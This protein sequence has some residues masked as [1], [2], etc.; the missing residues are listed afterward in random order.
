MIALENELGSMLEKLRG[1]LS[2][3]EAAEKSGL[4]HT[5]I[6][7][8]ERGYNRATKTP[9][10]PS[11]DTLEKLAKA[12]NTSYRELMEKAGY[13]DSSVR[14][15]YAV[16]NLTPFSIEDPNLIRIP[17]LGSIR[18]GQPMDRIEYIEGYELAE[19]DA[20]RGRK[21]FVLRVQG[22]SMIGDYIFDG[23]RVVVIVQEEVSPSEIAVVAVNGDEA[24]LKRVKCL[25]G[26][27]LL[28]PSNTAME[29]MAFPAKDVHVIGVVVEVRRTIK[30]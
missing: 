9:I 7:D 8:I 14:E 17:I 1:K 24:T 26:T 27:C 19:R 30:R 29:A 12:Y 23:D 25:D 5:Y 4:S 28:I 20:I 16:Y 2:L 22:D 6:R 21:A 18:A 13:L 3:R 10:N 11:P 15:D